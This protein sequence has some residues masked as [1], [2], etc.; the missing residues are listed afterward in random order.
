[1]LASVTGVAGE[2]LTRRTVVGA[3][4]GAAA[5]LALGGLPAWAAPLRH[6]RH[7]RP[8]RADSLPVPDQPMGTP[9]IPRA[10]DQ[11]VILMLENHSFD[12]IL[13]MLPYRVRSRRGVDGLPGD[14]RVPTAANPDS[15][16]NPVRSFHLPDL[17]PST[18]LTQAWDASH[19][20]YDNGRND[21]FVRAGGTT[22]P[23]GYFDQDDLPVTYALAAHFPI[24]DRYF[25]SALAQTYPNRRF[26]F[27]ATASGT[28][29]DDPRDFAVRAPNGTI[30]D[31]L[32]AGR[33]SWRVYY[34]NA[35]SP[36]ILPNFSGNPLDV[37]R[38]VKNSQF[39]TDA[40][41]GRLPQVSFVEP[42]FKTQSE[43]NPQDVAIGENFVA[44][45][46][47]AVQGGPRWPS[48][49][50]FITYDEHGGFFDHVPPP[51]AVTP[52]D[53][54]PNLHQSP[55]GGYRAGYDRYGFRVPLTVV[56]PWARAG[57]VS[58]MVSDHTSILSFVEHKWNLPALTRRDA[59][60]WPLTDMFDTRRAAFLEPP[61]LPAAPSIDATLA[62]CRADGHKPP[63]GSSPGDQL[64]V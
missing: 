29:S 53:T 51:A 20:A 22:T 49:A 39:F 12:N 26:L 34:D 3:G 18:G 57:Y 6:V 4:L 7:H 52:D 44:R 43:E 14:G 8:R 55:D 28:I 9:G 62:R 63:D 19:V 41:A 58:H 11:V 23:M 37:A 30:F 54:P 13:G 32:D 2:R 46:V 31:R 47:A 50:L 48:S 64:P 24:S 35:P 61:S 16:G 25:S 1:M 60:A 59:N 5:G 45:V 15:S 36:V 17:C 56:S 42:N 38:T 27:A 21:G 40:A 10:I 33:V